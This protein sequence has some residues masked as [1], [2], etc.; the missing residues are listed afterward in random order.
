MT[1]AAIN[2][3]LFLTAVGIIRLFAQPVRLARVRIPRNEGQKILAAAQ[4]GD[5]VLIFN[6]G[7]WGDFELDKAI[8]FAPVLNGIQAALKELGLTPAPMAYLRVLPGLKGRLAGTKEQLEMF[9]ITACVQAEDIRKAAEVFPDKIFLLV[10]FSVGGGLTARTLKRLEKQ[11][12][13]LGI[14][15]GVPAWY[16]T[17]RSE[18]S[19][20]LN[21]D[22]LDPLS[23]GNAAVMAKNVLLA[24]FVYLK[25]RLAGR[26]LSFAFSLRFPCHE[27]PWDSPRV[28]PPICEFLTRRLRPR[29]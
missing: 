14:T 23:A 12:N 25:E 15:I 8:D 26:Q 21:N 4:R 28:G 16:P 9:K 13:V 20:V 5:A 3:F 18:R 24:P 11:N 10:G 22:N 27:Y 29:S 6:G 2:R 1:I 7:G 19:L 17:Y